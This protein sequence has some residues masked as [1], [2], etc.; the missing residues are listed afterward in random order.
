MFNSLWDRRTEH[1]LGWGRQSPAGSHHGCGKKCIAVSLPIMD[2]KWWGPNWLWPLGTA[3]TSAIGDK[4]KV[5]AG[6]LPDK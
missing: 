4:K 2:G 5:P 1:S 3:L 6:S